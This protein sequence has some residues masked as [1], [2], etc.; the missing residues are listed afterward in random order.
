M[1]AVTRSVSFLP[2]RRRTRAAAKAHRQK[3]RERHLESWSGTKG[4][5]NSKRGELFKEEHQSIGDG[6]RAGND[7]SGLKS[8]LSLSSYYVN[9]S[10]SLSAAAAEVIA[11]I[12]RKHLLCAKTPGLLPPSHS[13][14]GGR[15]VPHC[16]GAMLSTACQGSRAPPRDGAAALLRVGGRQPALW[17]A[18]SPSALPSFQVSPQA[19]HCAVTLSPPIPSVHVVA[20]SPSRPPP[21][22]SSFH[23]PL[24]I[25]LFWGLPH[26]LA[27]FRLPS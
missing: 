27:P 26:T 24:L 12:F 10:R 9:Y 20:S 5:R 8:H 15:D 14:V 19:S 6:E 22:H 13:G 16:V 7:R 11:N 21:S 4:A 3:D 25:L 18:H 2:R 1:L 23:F 17:L